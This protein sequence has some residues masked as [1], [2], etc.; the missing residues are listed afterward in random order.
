MNDPGLRKKRERVNMAGSK[1]AG[2][3][4]M[5]GWRGTIVGI[6][7]WIIVGVMVAWSVSTIF[8]EIRAFHPAAHWTLQLAFAVA[9]AVSNALSCYLYVVFPEGSATRRASAWGIV[10]FGVGSAAVQ[11]HFYVSAG[12]ALI[13]GFVMG[14]IGPLAEGFFSV[15]SGF[16]A[17]DEAAYANAHAPAQVTK[18]AQ[19]AVHKPAQVTVQPV[20]PAVVQ[21][22]VQ[23]P[24]IAQEGATMRRLSEAKAACIAEGV[25]P[26]N[27]EISRRTGMHRNT[28]STYMKA[29]SAGATA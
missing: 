23:Q 29:A 5:R 15:I 16:M 4:G 8:E 18:P 13:P 9:F 24:T 6:T 25:Q 14:T 3:R 11:T 2:Q 12:L 17:Q 19:T 27:A 7:I 1:S 21:D 10:L 28:V 20:E 26:T 22:T